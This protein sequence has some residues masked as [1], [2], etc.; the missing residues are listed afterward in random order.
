MRATGHSCISSLTKTQKMRLTL[1]LTG[2]MFVV[3]ACT[4]AAEPTGP[5]SIAANAAPTATDAIRFPG[6]MAGF[7]LRRAAEAWQAP[8]P[9]PAVLAQWAGVLRQYDVAN[10][11]GEL[12]YLGTAERE[13]GA[14][15]WAFRVQTRQRGSGRATGDY[16][17]VF[18]TSANGEIVD[19]R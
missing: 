11:E 16:E 19:V 9:P 12:L 14:R 18:A 10:L 17:L 13:D 8:D 4:P 1:F 15:L 6:S 5:K 2:L 3:A 7:Q